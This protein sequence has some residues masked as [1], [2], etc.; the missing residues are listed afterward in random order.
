MYSLVSIDGKENKKLI[1]HRIK[2]IQSKLHRTRTYDVDKASLS[3]FDD[4]L[5]W[6]VQS[7]GHYFSSIYIEGPNTK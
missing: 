2:R 4:K 5:Q 3:S 1:R 7:F 6:H